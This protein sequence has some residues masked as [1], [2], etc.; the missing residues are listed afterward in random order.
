ML[1]FDDYWPPSE[2]HITATKD[3]FLA[4]SGLFIGIAVVFLFILIGKYS[5]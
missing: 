4:L 5:C 1:S 2:E 3:T